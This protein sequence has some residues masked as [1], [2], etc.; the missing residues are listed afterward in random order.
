MSQSQQQIVKFW[1]KYEEGIAKRLKEAFINHAIDNRGLL[2]S[3][4]Q[5]EAVVSKIMHI[6]LNY[7]SQNCKE[8][9]VTT[10]VT[11]L[12][13]QGLSMKAGAAMMRAIGHEQWLGTADSELQRTLAQKSLDFQLLFVEKLSSAQILIQQRTQE[14]SQKALQDALHAQIEQ[15]SQLRLEQETYNRAATKILTLNAHLASITDEAYLLDQAVSGICQA[16]DLANVTL[17]DLSKPENYWSVRTTTDEQ[18]KPHD[19][20]TN[21]TLNLLNRA[22]AEDGH[23]HYVTTLDNRPL[24]SA[25]HLIRSGG[26]VS[27]AV[28]INSNPLSEYQAI[29]LPVLL[30]TF[31][32]NLA[33]QRYNLQLFAETKQH[34]LEMEILY[35]RYIDSIWDPETAVLQ[36][37]YEHSDFQLNRDPLMSPPANNTRSIPVVISDHPIGHVNLPNDVPLAQ[38]QETF[39]H[40]LIREMS[41]A[42]NNAYL[43]QTTRA[44]SNQLSL[45]TEVSRAATTILDHELLS[46]EVVDLIRSRFN[47]YYVGLFLLD[48]QRETAV[49]QAG[50]GEAGRLQIERK[51]H[52]Q[53]GGPSMIGTCIANG[54]AIVEQDVTQARAFKFNPLLPDTRSELAMPLRTR[55]QIIGALTV[56]SIQKGAF[57]GETIAVLQSLADQL[58]IAIENASL[59]AQIQSTL[60]ETNL[61]YQASRQISEAQ[62]ADGVYEALI[63]FARDS[64]QVDA[65]YIAVI[66]EKDP[67]YLISPAGWSQQQ[68]SV[69]QLPR[70]PF[71]FNT[72]LKQNEIVLITDTHTDTRLDNEARQLFLKHNINSS[73]LIPIY[74]EGTW[75]GTFLLHRTRNEP[76]T[77]Q[78]LPPYRTLADQAAII[79]ANQKLFQEIKQANE[80]LRQLDQ[81][82]TQFL[83]NM[84][85]ELR[86]PLNSIIG[87]SR[88]ILKGIDGPITTEQ[89]EDLSS[90][91][92]N[93]QHLLSLINE[94]LDMAKIEAGKMA[95]AYEPVNVEATAHT[96]FS[97]IRALVK[98]GVKLIWD[99]QAGLPNIEA[100]QVRVRQILTNLLSNATKFTHDGLIRLEIFLEDEDHIHIAVHDTGIGIAPEEFA[101][102]FRAFEQVDNSTTSQCRWH[103][104]GAAHN[105]MVSNHAWGRYLGR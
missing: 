57:T 24:L 8:A 81:L 26:D 40:D 45:A 2:T 92:S 43:L 18:I 39:V 94:I 4:R 71:A 62:T 53:V 14:H 21:E 102:L 48:E 16:L 59:F 91:H 50:T 80:Q 103:R 52:Q 66:D 54:E 63:N 47:L 32:Q 1:Q 87:F 85:H 23:L 22:L 10:V 46:K 38:E 56:Q 86:T 77:R 88:V 25:T 93:G 72:Q 42:L 69:T 79:L 98:P 101:V 28:L 35:G 49:L 29:N 90:I 9:D 5:T 3:T 36:A 15:Q 12:A 95:L 31:T 105:K 44:T 58:A 78:M 96:A 65:A 82:K 6:A 67:A 104:F 11:E 99:V 60:A 33:S 41:N 7:L 30:R 61:L 73:A 13:N 20:I 84:S 68:I 89:E 34:S 64:Q 27:G 51:H 75:L 97:S 19:I 76:I 55:G 70:R 100:D 74:M 83:A 37:S 17:Y